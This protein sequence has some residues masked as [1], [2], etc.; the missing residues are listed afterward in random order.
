MREDV[1]RELRNILVDDLLVE[2]PAESIGEADGLQ[3]VVG[4]DS[5][6][7]IELRVACEQRFG[8]EISDADFT[9]ENFR[10]LGALADLVVRVKSGPEALKGAA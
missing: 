5:L 7:F 2:L 4:L 8:V 3:S 1:V 6:G 9:S 10:S